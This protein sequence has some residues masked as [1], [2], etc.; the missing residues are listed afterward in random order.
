MTVLISEDSRPSVDSSAWVASPAVVV[1]NVTIG[2]RASVWYGAVV[3]GDGD[4]ITISAGS[5][6]Q[7]GCVVHSDP[8]Y[9]VTIG[10]NVSVGHRAVL[11][12]C[13]V[14][15]DVLIGMGAL[16]LNGA[17][18]G[19]GSTIAAGTLV[20]EGSVVPANSMVAG[21]PGTVRRDTTEDERRGVVANAERYVALRARH[22]SI[23]GTPS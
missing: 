9:P 11:H 10:A 4:S 22:G 20:L 14:E 16:I 18:I 3:R 12:G 2:P 15:D 8:G 7:D 19:R 1:G 5:N 17:H 23:S 6:I 21:L 13:T